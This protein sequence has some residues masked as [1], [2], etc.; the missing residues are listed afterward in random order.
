MYFITYHE[1]GKLGGGKWEVKISEGCGTIFRG[2]VATEPFSSHG[3]L[4][5]DAQF[6]RVRVFQL[7]GD[8]QTLNLQNRRKNHNFPCC[9]LG[10][11]GS[12][13]KCAI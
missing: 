2:T 8:S 6:S 1:G 5:W 9:Q 11:L 7:L 3:F 12:F 4:H 13:I 10:Y